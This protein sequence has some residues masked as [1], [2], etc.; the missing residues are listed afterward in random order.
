MDE[1]I[2]VS[3]RLPEESGRVLVFANTYGE[4]EA[5]TLYYAGHGEWCDND[6]WN[7][8][9]GFGITHWQ[10]LPPPPPEAEK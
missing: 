4:W 3:E 5:T 9:E 8:T 6:G 1:W 2:K 10:K 7:T